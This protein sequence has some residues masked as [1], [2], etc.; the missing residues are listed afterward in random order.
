MSPS[1]P[2]DLAP[3]LSAA[4]AA[5]EQAGHLLRQEFHRRGG[6]RG[7]GDKADIDIEIEE[8]L[9]ERLLT[10]D[11]RWHWMGE[12][13]PEHSGDLECG[14]RWVV[15]PHDGTSAFLEGWR[16]TAV[17]IALL[18]E[19]RPVLGVVH[20]FAAPDDA[21]DLI[22][23]AEG[24]GP[25]LRNG[26]PVEG[27]RTCPPVQERLA[28]YPAGDDRILV[29][30]PVILAISQSARWRTRGNMELLRTARYI[31]IPSIAYRLALA[32]VGDIDA[33]VSL[34]SPCSWDFA[35]GHALLRGAGGIL[36]DESGSEIAYSDGYSEAEWCAGGR[37]EV[38]RWCM[39][40]DWSTVLRTPRMKR[41]GWPMRRDLDGTW[42]AARTSD[43]AVLAR[44]H[45]TLLG[46]V[47]G[48]SLGALVEFSTADVIAKQF[49][50]GIQ[51]LVDGGYWDLFAGQP[52]D[53]SELALALARSLVAAGGFDSD[54]VI[55]AYA[56]WYV[57]GPFDI[58]GTTE[59][60]LSA[61]AYPGHLSPLE[62]AAKAA[63]QSS[64]ANGALMRVSPIGI[65]CAGDPGRAARWAA[66]DASLTHPHPV[67][68][69][70][71]AAFAAAV[72]VGVA[73]GDRE[74][75]VRTA[76]D[77]AGTGPEAQRVRGI[78]AQAAKGKPA[79]FQSHMGWVLIAL[80]NAFHHLIR[81][82]DVVRT[83][84]ETV[85]QGGD[86]DTNA[87]IAGA[88]VGA[89]DGRSAFPVRWLRLVEACRPG[90]ESQAPEARRP[91][92]WPDDI[93]DLAEALLA[94]QKTHGGPAILPVKSIDDSSEDFE[95]FGPRP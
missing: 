65:A 73:T 22:A 39:Q 12:E 29:E 42:P 9:R 52:T 90:P 34:A 1:L 75:M 6:P 87:A 72:A 80:E 74:A 92:Y 36:V 25:I 62:A 35:A 40:Q 24:C 59:A 86:S 26:K 79:D 5:A 93:L 56:H 45:G 58:G 3:V 11:Q 46:Q 78:I 69:A 20:A 47:A 30:D 14:F 67:C 57:A 27:W 70:A 89:A 37:P 19:D 63:R 31:A 2:L 88:L 95:N 23:W 17:S 54:R 77:H 51:D 84:R 8:M 91:D 28:G 48:D 16:G 41:V 33:G 15:D 43:A 64:E 38:A 94:L 44:A 49:P 18:H 61:A 10:P 7:S 66:M 71:S 50:H 85:L 55:E 76:V 60:A 68:Q 32:A 21:G 13:T 4:I 81:G 53:D 82:H 83:I